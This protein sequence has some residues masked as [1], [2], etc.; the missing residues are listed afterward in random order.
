VARTHLALG[1]T[2]GSWS[3]A[4]CIEAELSGRYDV[5]RSGRELH[6]AD[7]DGAGDQLVAVLRTLE[8]CMTGNDLGPIRLS[9]D[10]KRYVMF[11]RAE[12]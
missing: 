6:V 2:A 7:R 5:F 11:A 12:A 4:D 8:A 1:I 3:E 10:G 9:L